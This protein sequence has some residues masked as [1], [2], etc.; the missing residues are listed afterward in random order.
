MV[1]DYGLNMK[2]KFLKRF[3]FTIQKLKERQDVVLIS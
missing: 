3:S 1:I 2:G